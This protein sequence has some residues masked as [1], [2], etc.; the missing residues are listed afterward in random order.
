MNAVY[1]W[2]YFQDEKYGSVDYKRNQ[3]IKLV[4]KERLELFNRFKDQNT[5]RDSLYHYISISV[6]PWVGAPF[7]LLFIC[8]C[9]RQFSTGDDARRQ[10][11]RN[12]VI[13]DG[14]HSSCHQ[15][16]NEDGERREFTSPG[17]PKSYLDNT[18]CVR[19][20]EGGWHCGQSRYLYNYYTLILCLRWHL[21]AASGTL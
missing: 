3:L 1:L 16:S 21:G 17:Y 7:N 6:N 10:A 11:D 13:G 4:T 2:R 14:V 19:L 5:R 9:K 8:K 20:I 15:F 12:H 18:S